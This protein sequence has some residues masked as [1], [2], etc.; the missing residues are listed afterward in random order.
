M[1]E[2]KNKRF[3]SEKLDSKDYEKT[4]KDAGLIKGALSVGAGVAAF[5]VGV[6]KYIKGK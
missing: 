2:K 4:E 1:S 5:A 6:I 3:E